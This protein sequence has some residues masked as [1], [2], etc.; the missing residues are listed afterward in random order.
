MKICC[1]NC[2]KYKINVILGGF[3]CVPNENS[4]GSHTKTFLETNPEKHYCDDFEEKEFKITGNSSDKY[5]DWTITI[6]GSKLLSGRK[7][8]LE[9][10]NGKNIFRE[11]DE[12]LKPEFE[13]ERCYF[14][15]ACF[16]KCNYSDKKFT[17]E[18]MNLSEWS[19]KQRIHN[20]CPCYN[21]NE[22]QDSYKKEY[23]NEIKPFLNKNIGVPYIS[24]SK[25]SSIFR[26]AAQCVYTE[27]LS[28]KMEYLVYNMKNRNNRNKN[29]IRIERKIIEWRK[30][31]RPI[32]RWYWDW[33]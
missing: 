20:G 32:L 22:I 19:Q 6:N 21:H 16:V 24:Y 1:K 27:S 18:K 11:I 9:N 31:G 12:E 14:V 3:Y 25:S 33:K 17:F 23:E 5:L 10:K 2:V 7:F 4:L 8:L 29:R 30:L 15:P 26:K 28:K 13:S